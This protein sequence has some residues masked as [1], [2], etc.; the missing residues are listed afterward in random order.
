MSAGSHATQADLLATAFAGLGQIVADPADLHFG[1]TFRIAGPPPSVA[2]LRARVAERVGASSPLAERLV[3]AEGAR[4]ERAAD[5]D[6]AEHVRELGGSGPAAVRSFAALPG[7][8]PWMLLV[9]PAESDWRLHYL[10]H[11]ARQDAQAALRTVVSLLGEGR[12]GSSAPSRPPGWWTPGSL[13]PGV[14]RTLRTGQPTAGTPDETKREFAER[15]IPVSILRE[16][17][18]A[19]KITVN[20]VLLSALRRAGGPREVLMPL[21]IRDGAD[22][23]FVNRIAL[24]RVALTSDRAVRRDSRRRRVARE[25]QAWRLLSNGRND[26]LAGW[27]LRRITNPATMTATVSNLRVDERI[28]LLGKEVLGISAIPWL[29]PGHRWFALLVTYLADTTLT[30]LAQSEADKLVDAWV[31]AVDDMRRREDRR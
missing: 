7:R 20:Q 5:F 6:P 11:H 28:T 19:R 27:M 10:V 30:V 4:W 18:D 21:S 15:V 24:T 25:R 8:P 26:R 22:S 1:L 17:A 3:W 31:S 16:V 12:T 2:E 23:E 13:V 9:E 29:P 14:L